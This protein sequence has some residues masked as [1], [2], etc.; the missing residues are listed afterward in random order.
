MPALGRVQPI[1][2]RAGAD[3]GADAGGEEKVRDPFHLFFSFRPSLLKG[4]AARWAGRRRR[5]R[6]RPGARRGAGGPIWRRERGRFGL[7]LP[8]IDV[9]PSPSA[10]P[11]NRHPR[12][13]AIRNA[14]KFALPKDEERRRR[15]LVSLIFRRRQRE[16]ALVRLLRPRPRRLY[17]SF[18]RR[19]EDKMKFPR[20]APL[21]LYN[22]I[23]DPF[24][25]NKRELWPH[26]HVCLPTLS[27]P[28]S[29]SRDVSHPLLS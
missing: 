14:R 16:N 28:H 26:T 29:S 18:H 7:P 1:L 6:R 11:A 22:R 19:D 20:G 3:A 8:S 13:I 4:T 2:L 17:G 12:S 27:S 21:A 23:P 24:G 5:R 15:H 9:K 10:G 25:R